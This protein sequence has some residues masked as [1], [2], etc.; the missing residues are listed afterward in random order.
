MN[1][2]REAVIFFYKHLP[3]PVALSTSRL[4]NMLYLTDW[5]SALD[6][7]RQLSDINWV[8]SPEGPNQEGLLDFMWSDEKTFGVGEFADSSGKRNRYLYLRSDVTDE[9]HFSVDE[10]K[11][12][13]HVIDT[14]KSRNI[15]DLLK[16]VHS[17]YPMM[18]SNLGERLD[19]IHFALEYK[20][21]GRKSNLIPVT[22]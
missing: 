19:L 15:Y 6:Y 3:S 18:K 17:T 21:V 20:R 16:L 8:H 4:T 11:V 1:K 5:K 9:Y 12:V 14:T 7:N 2:I 22:V 10:Q 13:Q